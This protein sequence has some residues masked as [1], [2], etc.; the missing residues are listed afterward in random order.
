MGFRVSRLGQL[1]CLAYQ[2]KHPDLITAAGV[3]T[4]L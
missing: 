1:R 4:S 2:P 3:V